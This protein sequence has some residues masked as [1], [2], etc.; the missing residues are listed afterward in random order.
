MR[1]ILFNSIECT[2][3]TQAKNLPEKD[4]ETVSTTVKR[5]KHQNIAAA[6]STK[7]N[8]GNALTSGISIMVIT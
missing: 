2:S 8:Y 6:T 3:K 5:H 4:R 7:S 1:K